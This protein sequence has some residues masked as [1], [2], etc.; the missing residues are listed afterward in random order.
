MAVAQGVP[1]LN[2]LST[3]VGLRSELRAIRAALERQVDRMDRID[4]DLS[5][6]ISVARAAGQH[7]IFPRPA[8]C[9]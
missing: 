6:V 5:V 1:K 2:L 7:V 4:R 8:T 3:A 9:R